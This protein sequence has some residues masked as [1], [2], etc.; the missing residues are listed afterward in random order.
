MKKDI[1]VTYLG[2]ASIEGSGVAG[3]AR[4]KSTVE[5]LNRIRIKTTLIAFSFHSNEFKIEKR[6]KNDLLSSTTVYTPNSLPRFLKIFS[7]IPFFYHSFIS[8]RKSDLIITDFSVLTA[9]PALIISKILRKPVILDC[10]DTKL[11]RIIPDS[12]NKFISRNVDC[13]FAIST[14][15]VGV[16]KKYNENVVFV[17]I[18]IDTEL[19]KLS[20]KDRIQI[21]TEL[22]IEDDEIVI[23]YA[24]SFTYYEGVANLIK[25]F[26]KLTQEYSNIKLA[27]MG[28]VYWPKLDD[29]VEG[30]VDKF[31]LKEKVLIIPSKAHNEVPKFLSAFDV[32]CVPKLDDKINRVTQPVKVV[33]F[34]SMGTV[35]VA[36]SVGGIIDTID[37]FENGILV[38]PGDVDDL[39][40]KLKWVI[41]NRSISQKVGLNGRRKIKKEY[42]YEAAEKIFNEV[43]K[44]ITNT[45]H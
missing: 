45:K 39:F 35:T 44:D 20:K 2:Q 4:I 22:D 18:F 26:K 14:Y 41:E 1:N 6:K 24:G 25:A 38:K 9:I 3:T 19:F 23:G 17:P 5:I 13:V 16:C 42:S 36:A 7:I 11:I 33:E 8:C 32:L 21:R 27:I 40:D 12:L 29:D 31:N 28:K 10:I 43:I 34:M 30:L 37:D 15:F